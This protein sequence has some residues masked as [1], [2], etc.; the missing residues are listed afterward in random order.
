M[1]NLCHERDKHSLIYRRMERGSLRQGRLQVEPYLASSSGHTTGHGF[2]PCN[3]AE[4][5]S[6]W[7]KAAK[8]L[9]SATARYP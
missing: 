4:S 1:H 5:S 2:S 3:H 9:A 7:V 6:D 8:V